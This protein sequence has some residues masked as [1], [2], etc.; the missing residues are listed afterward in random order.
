[1]QF[2]EE[3]T[4]TSSVIVVHLYVQATANCTNDTASLNTTDVTTENVTS[5]N[6]T[7]LNDT[8]VTSDNYTECEIG[9][10]PYINF[11]ADFTSYFVGKCSS[12]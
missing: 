12:A 4:T 7:S 9:S 5:S 11:T 10:G 3:F 6:E 2:L 8:S 1:M